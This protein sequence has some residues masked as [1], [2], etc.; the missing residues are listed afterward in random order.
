MT[1][2]AAICKALL[3]GRVLSIMD[4][5]KLFNCTNLPREL[6]RSVEKKFDVEISKTRVEFTSTYGQKG[7]YFRYRLNR[8]EYNAPGIERM[9]IYI[10]EQMEGSFHKPEET[11]VAQ[12]ELFS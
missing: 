2:V 12:P 8:T 11:K 6:S 3:D 5:F 7:S 10:A 9:K 1:Q 4:G